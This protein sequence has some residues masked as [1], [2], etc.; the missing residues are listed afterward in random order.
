MKILIP[1]LSPKRAAET[2]RRAAETAGVR[3]VEVEVVVDESGEGFTATVNRGLEG[4]AGDIC[5][6]NDDAV[7]LTDGWLAI[8]KREMDRRETLKV[9]FAGPSGPCRTLPQSEG[10]VG[11]RRRPRLVHHLAGFCLLI[12]AEAI[13]TLGGLDDRFIHYASDIDYQFRARKDFGARSL[14]VPSVYVEHELHPPRQ[15]WWDED[16]QL[17]GASWG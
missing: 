4:C 15:P 11:D 3:N 8:L 12:K 13:E 17:F 14:W 5:L 10:R 2:M 1:T 16:Q 9:W 6:L 7:P